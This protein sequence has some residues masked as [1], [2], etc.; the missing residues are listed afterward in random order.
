M[1][2]ILTN[3][4]ESDSNLIATVERLKNLID[5]DNDYKN[6]SDSLEQTTIYLQEVYQE[7]KNLTASIEINEAK[8]TEIE[9]RISQLHSIARK[10]QLNHPALE[11]QGIGCD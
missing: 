8:L 11:V 3:V 1:H 9:Q 10:H 6:L 5:N 4:Y 2:E 7:A